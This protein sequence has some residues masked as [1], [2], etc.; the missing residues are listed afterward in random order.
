[1]TII[2]N[3]SDYILLLAWH[4]TEPIIKKWKMKGLKS[5]LLHHYQKK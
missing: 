2:E 1:M 4:L 3:E 5:N